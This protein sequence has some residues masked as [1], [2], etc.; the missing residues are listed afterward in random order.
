[1]SMTG[2]VI[3]SLRSQGNSPQPKYWKLAAHFSVA[4][5]VLTCSNDDGCPGVNKTGCH[6]GWNFCAVKMNEIMWSGSHI[7]GI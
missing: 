1:M 4:C 5:L 7:V 2:D 6:C 3:N